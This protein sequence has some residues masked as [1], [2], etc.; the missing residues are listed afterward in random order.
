MGTW[1]RAVLS[2]DFARDTY[3]EFIRSFNAGGDRAAITRQMITSSAEEISDS[4]DGPIFWLALAKAQWDTGPVD[5]EVLPSRAHRRAWRGPR[6][7]EG[8]RQSRARKATTGPRRVR[9]SASVTEPEAQEG[10]TSRIS[11]GDLSTYSVSSSRHAGTIAPDSSL[12]GSGGRANQAREPNGTD[13]G[14]CKSFAWAEAAWLG[15]LVS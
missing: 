14:I 15:P 1:G 5:Q 7:V 8:S 3:D 9:R 12:C 4:D 10:E 11:T 6:S 2:D 13:V